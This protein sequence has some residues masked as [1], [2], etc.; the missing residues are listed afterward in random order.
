MACR[1]HEL[2]P[3]LGMQSTEG[4][5]L[6]SMP[7]DEDK[8]KDLRYITQCERINELEIEIR[9]GGASE[10]NNAHK[11]LITRGSSDERSGDSQ[12]IERNSCRLDRCGSSES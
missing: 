4:T 9:I 3:Q 7:V 6:V 5:F 12:S 1:R 11:Y 2:Q 10:E 8:K